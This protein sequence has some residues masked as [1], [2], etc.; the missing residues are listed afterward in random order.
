LSNGSPRLY[1]VIPVLDELGNLPSLFDSFRILQGQL[2]SR[3]D[4]RF[5]L[6]D[7]GSRDGTGQ[8]AADLAG[9]L[10]LTVLTHPENR[11]PGIAFSTAFE[12]LS[13]RL[14]D[15]DWVATMEGD[16]TSRLE[17]LSQML[18]RAQEGYEVVLAS[19]YMYGGGITNVAA[20][21]VMLS[22]MANGFAKQFLGCH[23][24]LTVSSFFRLFQGAALRKL[25]DHYGNRILESPGFECMLEMVIKMVHLRM[26]I[27]EVPMVLDTSIGVHNSKMR[28]LRTI[29]GYLGL[30][31][32]RRRWLAE[33]RVL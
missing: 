28:L 9:S 5:I 11:G 6:V 4:I 13:S 17:L 10:D 23:G 26:A 30:Y 31:R 33:V 27:S 7:D 14:T 19:P 24:L 20:H 15:H 16:N 12:H 8:A 18:T 2:S 25:M 1:F 22:H 32:K 21:R 3:Y 29:R